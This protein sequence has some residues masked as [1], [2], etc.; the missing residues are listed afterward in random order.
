MGIQALPLILSGVQ[1]GLGLLQRG[2]A[3]NRRRRAL[4]NMQYNIPSA[5]KE[6]VQLAREGASQTGLPGEDITRSRIKSGISS[7]L[8]RGEAA[9]ETSSDVLGLYAQLFGQEMDIEKQILEKGA[10]Y[11]SN[12]ELQLMKSLGLMSE[13]ENQQ[14]Y[15]NRFVP[16]MSEMG[17]ASEQAQGGAANIAGGLQTAYGAWLNDWMMDQYQGLNQNTT[18]TG[19]PTSLGPFLTQKRLEKNQE[20]WTNQA[21]GNPTIQVPGY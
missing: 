11:K 17:Y 3:N 6:Q 4:E 8:S 13:A 5:T 9:S 2:A 7:A 15:Y 1:T 12:Q 16:F 18:S 10:E 19:E 14:F 21:L 20:M